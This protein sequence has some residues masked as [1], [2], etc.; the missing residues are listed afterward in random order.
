MEES[1]N[2]F[3]RKLMENSY[4]KSKALRCR[5][6]VDGVTWDDRVLHERVWTSCPGTQGRRSAKEV[7]LFKKA[8]VLPECE[9][10][11][12]LHS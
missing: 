4:R 2:G 7:R 11:D 9:V 8:N 12:N 6:S 3:G 5:E 10:R 1:F